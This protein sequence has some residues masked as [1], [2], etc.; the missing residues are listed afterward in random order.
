MRALEDLVNVDQPAWPTLQ[1]ALGRAAVELDVQP[2]GDGASLLQLQVSAGSAL[3]AMVLH[4]GGLVLDGG[5]LRIFGGRSSRP[6]PALPSLAV[7][8][9]FPAA[10]DPAW[11]PQDALVVGHD[12]LG[13]VFALNTHD[14]AA[15]GR[16]GMPGQMTYFAPDSLE[17]EAMDMGYG[18][19]LT[20]A[21]TDR[22]A[23]FYEGLRWPGWQQ[24]IVNLT[25]A[26]GIT[27]YPFLW[28]KEAQ[29]DLAA[30]TR[31]P[32]PIAELHTM[33]QDFC[34]Q[35]GLPAAGFLGAV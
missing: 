30:T 18:T 32:A 12:V 29:D 31:A 26:E 27:V 4:C 25:A 1:E 21:L 24:E 5:W 17:W 22:V 2:G 13:G 33:N 9:G 14:P 20:W 16:P 7:V 19:W 34:Q 6:R 28:S 3:G 10:V 15:A 35:M 11:R 23:H 8:N